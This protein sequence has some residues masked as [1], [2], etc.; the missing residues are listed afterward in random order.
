MKYLRTPD[1]R[2][3]NLPGYDFAPHYVE[4]ND[5]TGG[6]LR[7]HYPADGP[8]VLLMHGEP[9]WCYLYR[10][11]IPALAAAGL[12]CIAPDLIGFG[13]SDKPVER[14]DYTYAR[15]VAWMQAFLDRTA[16]KDI[17]LVCQDWGGLIG[18]RLVAANPALFARVVTANTFLPTGDQPASEAFLKWQKFSQEVPVFPAGGII[19]GGTVT[20]LT[21]EIIAAYD[22]PFPDESYKS[23]ARQFPQLVPT[24]PND[25][26]ADANRAAWKVLKTWTNPFL[27]AFSDS[28]PITKGADRVL[29]KLI[30]GAAGQ[31]HTTLQG[32]GHFLQE[33]VGQ[34]LAKTVVDFIDR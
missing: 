25:P 19:K 15:H 20:P 2:F 17:T 22:A 8:I 31:P 9:S 30:P 7:M 26:E 1:D 33:D 28:D 29:Q 16:L 5:T 21:P 3:T 14:G 18:L 13:R 11:M 32:G 23:G 4:I 24:A 12:R 6:K 10:H 34:K 27:T